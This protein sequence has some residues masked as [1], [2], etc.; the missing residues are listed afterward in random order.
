SG[1]VQSSRQ[2]RDRVIVFLILRM[3]GCI[4]HRHTVRTQIAQDLLPHFRIL[5]HVI[6]ADRV[7]HQTTDLARLVMTRDTVRVQKWAERRNVRLR[8]SSN[9]YQQNEDCEK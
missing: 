4:W 2:D 5:R 3:S 9:G 8:S 1:F 7:E 6:L